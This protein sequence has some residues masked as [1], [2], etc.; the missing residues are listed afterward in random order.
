[1]R[2]PLRWQT[3]FGAWVADLS[4]TRVATELRAHGAPVTESAVYKWVAG[5]RL[6]RP[7]VALHL[8]EISNGQISLAD[9]YAHR[10]ELGGMQLRTGFAAGAA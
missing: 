7:D 8:V 3:H 6:P 1:M 9:V 2:E 4:P 5:E 10:V